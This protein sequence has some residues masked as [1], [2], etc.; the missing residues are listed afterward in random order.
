MSL[1]S[2]TL[3]RMRVAALVAALGLTAA[4]S[5]S[6]NWKP[7]TELEITSR[8]ADNQQQ[9]MQYNDA[10]YRVL[11]TDPLTVEWEYTKCIEVKSKSGEVDEICGRE[12]L[13]RPVDR[14]VCR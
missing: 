4:C 12:S 3:S 14:V 8:S 5:T 1:R 10:R 7:C 11:D 9:R 13:A 2:A 6:K